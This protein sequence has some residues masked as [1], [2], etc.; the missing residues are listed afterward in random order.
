[1]LKPK[2]LS[3]KMVILRSPM[4]P[5]LKESLKS[6]KGSIASVFFFS[7]FINLL[8]LAVPLYMLQI[9]AKVL[10]SRSM[11]TLIFLT[12]IALVAVVA[13]GVLESVRRTIMAK[14]GTR[15]DNQL[16]E[17]L[18]NSSINRTI[19]KGRS[20]VNVMRNLAG[21][22]QFLSGS[23]VFPLLDM[24]W[25]PLFLFIMYLLHPLLG[26]AGLLA[27]L[28][29]V[30]FACFNEYATREPVGLANK[31]S[32]GLM[33]D[34]SSYMKN[35][36]VIQAMGMQ[37]SIL[38]NWKIRNERSL[39][40]NYN[41][42]RI[43]TKMQSVSKIVGSFL[44]VG[45][46]FLVVWLILQ[47]QI[48][49]G[50]MLVSIMLLGKATAP[51][52]QSIQSWKSVLKARESFQ[53]ISE[54][55][56]HA[57]SLE[58]VPDMPTPRGSL[59]AEGASFR[60]P[61]EKLPVFSRAS[62]SVT[63][64]TVCALIGPT[65]AGKSTMLRVLAGVVAPTAGKVTLGG[66]ELGQ[67]SSV[68]RGP[69]VGFLPQDVSLF[70]G[71]ISENISRLTESSIEAVIEAAK[72]ANSH[73]MIQ[74]LPL[75]YDTS[76]E[77][78]GL[79]LSGG[80]RQR[81]GLARAVY[82]QPAI[83]LL[84]EPDANLDELGRSELRNTL[85]KLRRQGIAVLMTTHRKSTER[86]AD[87]VYK[88]E[89]GKVTR[90]RK[91][92]KKPV[93][94]KVPSLTKQV[95]HTTTAANDSDTQSMDVAI[96]AEMTLP[97]AASQGEIFR[98]SGNSL[99]PSDA[100][101]RQVS[102]EPSRSKKQ[103]NSSDTALPQVSPE[104]STSKEQPSSSDTALPQVSPGASTSKEQQDLAVLS[105]DRNAQTT[106]SAVQEAN[107]NRNN[108]KLNRIKMLGKKLRKGL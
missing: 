39:V 35:A 75:G 82:G 86:L 14:M 51:L 54:Y 59:R 37:E 1:M 96:E 76:L 65:G 53:N 81:I 50:V 46:L 16:S 93:V 10:P 30:G 83:V 47:Q 23:S 45:I 79:N 84:D 99:T 32:A 19:H 104:P 26:L 98:S 101:T 52:E 90:V 107:G 31:D 2:M 56:D 29:M 48:S 78:D 17:H 103:K 8:T 57:A 27:A 89:S 72:L 61:G 108:R 69:A 40:A 55:L 95:E 41:A 42:G 22:R 100:A 67:W 87:E 25:T 24:P 70:A 85:R 6:F 80:Q 97:I 33:E 105:N 38:K 34:A 63:P 91:S 49:T 64:G 9:Y 102:P 106:V 92:R 5:F 62:M 3:K 12:G 73:E 18:L 58:A 94:D 36:D 21:I 71:T 74:E 43:N 88:I 11:D 77:E 68:Q 60:R 66:Y 13:L 7:F 44:K 28:V 20:S 4:N 15:F